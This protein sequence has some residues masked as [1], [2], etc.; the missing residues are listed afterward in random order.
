M[1]ELWPHQTEA[2][3][4]LR[5]TIAQ[6][7]R[8]IVVQAPTG[9]GKTMLS[10]AIVDG[11]LKKNNRIAFVVPAI[12]L[13]DQTVEAF[14]AEGLKNVGVIQASHQLSDWSKPV[15]VCSIQTIARRGIF[16]EAKTVIFDECHVLHKAHKTWMAHVDWQGVPFIGLSATPWSKGLGKYFDTLLVAVTTKEL[17][18]KGFL[19]QFKVF[20][21]SHPDLKNVKVVA[22]DYHEGQ[23]SG[24]MQEGTLSADIIDT[25]KK[26]WGKDKTLC[27]AVDC[28]HAKALQ[29]RFIAA[30]ISCGYQDAY[31]PDLERKEIKRKFHTGELRVVANVGTLTTGVD[32]PVKCLILARPT[33]SEILYTQIIGRA[34]RTAPDKEH[35]LILDHT[36]TT[37]RLGF[38][39]D[40]HHEM[41]DGGKEHTRPQQERKAPLPKLCPQCAALKPVG[42][43]VCQNCGFQAVVTSDLTEDD[44]IELI[45]LAGV[46]S[47]RKPAGKRVWSTAEKRSFYAQLLGYV[48][49]HGYKEGWAANKYREKFGV[50]PR[51]MDGTP[52]IR[53][54]IEV[55]SWIRS[56][57][58]KW[59]KSKKREEAILAAE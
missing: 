44:T 13:V 9:S 28:A 40:I 45:E 38:V 41:L 51:G 53:P 10:A 31:T 3:S 35:A 26:R 16:P 46:T 47:F 11:A 30:G 24:A 54:S 17:I 23:L 43:K 34:L 42:V 27:F 22:G 20:A 32:W 50:W 59:A 57:Q 7:V 39:T 19:S 21:P 2:L 18:D 6:G 29:E 14:Y 8:R 5:Q 12:A 48:R 36:G 4:A 37:M 1:R 25:W 58:I 15:Q 56:G 49:E 55:A 33:K 52:A